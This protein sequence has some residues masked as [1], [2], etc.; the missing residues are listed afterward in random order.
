MKRKYLFPLSIIALLFSNV[1][2]AQVF[3]SPYIGMP[4]YYG[5][6]PPRRYRPQEQLPHF[7]PVVELSVGYG[8]PNLDKT[9][10]PDYYEAYRNNTSQVGPFAGSLNYR[11]SQR[12]SIGLLVTHGT[13]SA[14]YYAVGSS[15]ALPVFNTKL[16]NW[17]FMLNLVNYL[18][19][20]KTVSPYTRI[21]I[22]INSW[23]QN[24]TDSSG[25]KLSMPPVNLP[26][27]AYQ[28]SLG[29]K[30]KLSKSTGFFV[31]AGYGK[32]IVEGGLTF[33]L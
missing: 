14:P 26:D 27:L 21:A 28:V 15:S 22:G 1:A 24:Y 11:F 9:Y 6:R 19:G 5:P 12:T 3:I 29:A 13:V 10:L 31:E 17:A 33:K 23:Q 16:D 2:Q 20:S 25:N 7:D 30:F 8:F 18:P 4:R 32:Y